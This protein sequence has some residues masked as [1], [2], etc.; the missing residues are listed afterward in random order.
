MLNLRAGTPDHHTTRFVEPSLVDRTPECVGDVVTQLQRPLAPGGRND[1]NDRGV[2][3][4]VAT[5]GELRELIAGD[6]TR[7]FEVVA[8]DLDR[9][10]TIFRAQEFVGEPLFRVQESGRLRPSNLGA[11]GDNRLTQDF[12]ELAEELMPLRNDR[13]LHSLSA[14]ELSEL[15]HPIFQGRDLVAQIAL[16]DHALQSQPHHPM[17][18]LRRLERSHHR[19]GIE[20]DGKILDRDARLPRRKGNRG[21]SIDARSILEDGDLIDRARDAHRLLSG[22]RCAETEQKQSRKSKLHRGSSIRPGAGVR[23]SCQSRGAS[24]V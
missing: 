5:G 23:E 15:T 10:E 7:L 4:F 9:C 11:P 3:D 17:S 18:P 8:N 12:R 20:G 24:M 22:K 14:V 1:L 2:R 21:G 6:T 13:R 19:A 16:F